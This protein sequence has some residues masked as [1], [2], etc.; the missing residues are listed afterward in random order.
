L[1][2]KTV[3]FKTVLQAP[4]K[5]AITQLVVNKELSEVLFERPA[6]WFVYLE[7]KVKLGCPSEVEIER[8]AEAKAARDVLVHNRGIASKTYQM[9]AGRLA[10]F[11]DG[12][13]IDVPEQYHR[14]TWELIRKVVSDIS[15][16]AIAKV[17]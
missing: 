3:E 14:E 17:L 4:D 7:S 6:G 2:G 5:D 1:G 13:R 9:K 15:N 12:D 16:A 10:R 8:I 11:K